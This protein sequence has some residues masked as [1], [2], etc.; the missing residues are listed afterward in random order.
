[1]FG[2]SSTDSESGTVQPDVRPGSSRGAGRACGPRGGRGSRRPRAAGRPRGS[3]GG[4]GGA[5]PHIM[6][7]DTS[8]DDPAPLQHAASQ[9]DDIS[10]PST[11]RPQPPTKINK[12]PG[13]KHVSDPD[14]WKKNMA[15]RGR[16]EGRSYTSSTS[17]REYEAAKVGHP[18]RCPKECMQSMVPQAVINNVFQSFW[19]I[20]DNYSAKSAYLMS[21]IRARTVKRVRT[22]IPGKAPKP[23]YSYIV[24]DGHTEYEVCRRA[25]ASIHGIGLGKIEKIIKDKKKSTT[26]TPVQDR[27]GRAPSVNQISGVRLDHIHEHIQM[28][29]VTASHYSRAHSPH[30]RY[31]SSEMITRNLYDEYKHWLEETYPGEPPVLQSYYDRIFTTNYNIV[32]RKPKT[33]TCDVCTSLELRIEIKVDFIK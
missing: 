28:L 10:V 16:A 15:K 11:S 1:M 29:Q 25:F 23:Q 12:G 9:T 13:R 8:P 14:A 30:R 24:T 17:G 6:S 4:R 5:R 20:G 18:C 32:K 22:K 26:G 19:D 7:P 3:R 27:R 2:T 33:D 31:L 21:A